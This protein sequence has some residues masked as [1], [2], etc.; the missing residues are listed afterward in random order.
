MTEKAPLSTT[1]RMRQRK[2]KEK[3]RKKKKGKKKEKKERKKERKEKEYSW[4]TSFRYDSIYYLISG[5]DISYETWNLFFFL[6]G[7]VPWK[8]METRTPHTVW[9]IDDPYFHDI[10]LFQIVNCDEIRKIAEMFRC[11][12]G[13]FGTFF[14]KRMLKKP[15]PVCF[16]MVGLVGAW[17][18]HVPSRGYWEYQTQVWVAKQSSWLLPVETWTTDYLFIFS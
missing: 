17:P 2:E 15:R 16:A 14:F 10:S 8:L 3:Q 18:N 11:S 5:G 9:K 12:C 13:L 6:F 7:L 4:L 1:W